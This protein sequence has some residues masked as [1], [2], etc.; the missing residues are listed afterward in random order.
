MFLFF[1]LKRKRGEKALEKFWFC[2]FCQFLFKYTLI[3][4]KILRVKM[5]EMDI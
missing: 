2:D 1:S 4:F 5:C 3:I